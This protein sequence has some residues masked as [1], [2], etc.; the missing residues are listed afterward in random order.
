MLDRVVW[1]QGD[2]GRDPVQT[3]SCSGPVIW[4]FIVGGMCRGDRYG[5]RAGGWLQRRS[6]GTQ[7]TDILLFVG[8]S[9]DCCEVET[10][11]VSLYY[12]VI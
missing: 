11:V 12:I 2:G 8:F 1:A 7:T 10:Q 6:G 9:H 3:R 5:V 4:A